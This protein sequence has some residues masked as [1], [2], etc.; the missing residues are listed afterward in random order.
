MSERLAA[1]PE[2]PPAIELR[3]RPIKQL[4]QSLDPAPFHDKD[5]A[6]DAV[7]YIVG[8]ARDLPH[9]AALSMA[10]EFPAAEAD[11][12]EARGLEAAVQGYFAWRE[13]LA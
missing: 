6:P 12:P 2:S 7:A 9:G 1:G 5:L 3:L 10:V 4:F 8:R 11:L 13:E